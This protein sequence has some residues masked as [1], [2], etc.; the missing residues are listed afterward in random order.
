MCHTPPDHRA[1]TRNTV[2]FKVMVHKIHM[3]S[4]LPS[5]QGRQA[6]PDRRR[7]ESVGL[8]DRGIPGRS[9]ALRSLPRPEVRRGA[10][11]R[12]PE[13]PEP[14][15]LRRLPRQRQL[16]HR[17]ESREPAAGRP[18]TSAPP[19]T[20][21]QGELEFDASIKGAHT[22]PQQSA[23][24]PGIVVDI[25]KVENGGAGQKPT[26]TFTVRDS[27]GNGIP[28]SAMS[29]HAEQDLNLARS[30]HGLRLYE[31]R[32][33]RDHARVRHRKS[34]QRAQVLA[35]RH[36]H[37]HLYARHSG[38]RQ[39]HV[40]DRHRS[41]ARPHD[42]ARHGEAVA[43]RSTAPSIRCRTSRS[44]GRRSSKRRQVVD[45]AK[46]NGCH[47]SLSMHGDSRNQT[48]VL[49][50]LPQPEQYGPSNPGTGDQ[51]L[52]DGPQ[53]PLRRQHGAAR[54][55][56]T[57]SAASDFSDVRFPVM[58]NTGN[59]GRHGEVLHVPRERVGSGLPDRLEPGEDA[60]GPDDP[61]GPDDRR[62]H[63]LPREA[64]RSGPRD[65]A[66]RRQIRREL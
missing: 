3:G 21:P 24:R 50:L 1:N 33:G 66:D 25:V 61:D 44:M 19:A 23:T 57:R 42:P 34:G 7:G 51:L 4:Q 58:S 22:I 38:R 20:I 13:E 5:V 26:V 55:R 53:D 60:A 32:L 64:L 40:R 31:L 54:A 14:R 47:V 8:V 48:R 52:A 28:M 41:A 29:D 10:G 27:Q 15:G 39:R 9:A 16:R 30:H 36:V 18:T 63:R 11:R 17:R 2:D 65:V 37:L 56:R 59:A 62:L 6:V 35:R 49:R 45:I 46:C 12:L 43:A